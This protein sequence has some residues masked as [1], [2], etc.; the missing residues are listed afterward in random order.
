MQIPEEHLNKFKKLYKKQFGIELSDSEAL[1]K[2]TKL[3]R[4]VE[5][6]YKPMTEEEFKA[7]QKRREETKSLYE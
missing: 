1:D 6:V 2:A 3:I 5:I 4:L 7:L